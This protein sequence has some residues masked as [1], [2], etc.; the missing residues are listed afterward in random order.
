MQML[1]S[2]LSEGGG[3]IVDELAKN[4]DIDKNARSGG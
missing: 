4:F 2:I 1:D 3:A